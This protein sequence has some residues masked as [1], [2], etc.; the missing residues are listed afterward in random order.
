MDRVASCGMPVRDQ[1]LLRIQLLGP[2]RV[3]RGQRELPPM[4]PLQQAVLA[5]LAMRTGKIVSRHELIDAVW[6]S[7]SEKVI[8]SL[9]TYIAGLRKALEPER[10]HRAPG[11]VLVTSGSGYLLQLDRSQVDAVA[12]AD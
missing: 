11:Q 4:P 7:P 5:V 6:D 12:F 9:H 2:V 1:L 3:W 10:G 8:S